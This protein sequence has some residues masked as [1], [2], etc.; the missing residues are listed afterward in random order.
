V[1]GVSA[2]GTISQ[3]ANDGAYSG[4]SFD[5]VVI[6]HGIQTVRE[7]TALRLGKDVEAVTKE[8]LESDGP[9]FYYNG[10]HAGIANHTYRQNEDLLAAAEAP[11]F[12]LPLSK[13]AIGT[14]EQA[15]TPAQVEDIAQYLGQTAYA[16]KVAVVSLGAHSARVGRY[17]ERNKAILPEGVTFVRA[18]APLTHDTIGT[19]HREV[20][21]VL[22]YE[23]K[24]HLARQS[25]F[26]A[27]K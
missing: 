21:K 3:E 11:D 16:G 2:P 5:A 1:W 15:H 9:M 17:I 4:T 22:Q 6:N 10:E 12:P 27:D 13:I 23:K 24:G 14:I 18:A 7:I 8:D 26:S 19:V 20:T 25:Y